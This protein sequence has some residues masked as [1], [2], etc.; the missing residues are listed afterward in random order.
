LDYSESEEPSEE[1]KREMQHII[2]R[3]QEFKRGFQK[4]KH[5]KPKAKKPI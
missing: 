5:I 4:F 2:E 3:I 1:K